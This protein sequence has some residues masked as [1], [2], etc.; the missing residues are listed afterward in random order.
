MN[1][2]GNYV[3]HLYNMKGLIV[4]QGNDFVFCSVIAQ[5]LKPLDSRLYR[6]WF[7]LCQFTLNVKEVYGVP[8]LPVDRRVQV[9][10]GH[11]SS[12]TVEIHREEGRDFIE[13]LSQNQV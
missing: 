2:H 10:E 11:E 8:A 12:L 5:R 9:L 7:Q 13:D 6:R 1:K 4:P 3:L